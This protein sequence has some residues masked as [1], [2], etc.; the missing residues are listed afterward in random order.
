MDRA[1]L[2]DLLAMVNAA[3]NASSAVALFTGW[4]LI[5]RGK[6]RLHMRAMVTALSASARRGAGGSVRAAERRLRPSLRRSTLVFTMS[7][8]AH[9]HHHHHH[10]GP[11]GSR[12]WRAAF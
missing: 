4:I 8:L 2:G 5:R 7:R 3:L 6:V 11:P 12:R 10:H 9:T 1:Q